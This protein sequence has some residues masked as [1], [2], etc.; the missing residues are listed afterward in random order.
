MFDYLLLHWVTFFSAAFL[1]TLSPG[2]DI[3]F[4]LGQTI[5]GGRKAG[6]AAM[7]GIWGVPAAI[8]RA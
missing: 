3:A 5:K 4:I 8:C 2:P 1:L 7:F 6:F